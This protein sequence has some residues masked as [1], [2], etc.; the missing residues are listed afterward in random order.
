M[1]PKVSYK[2]HIAKTVT[3]RILASG[4]TYLL[5]ILFFK[6]DPDASEKAA[7]VA[8]IESALKMTFYYFHERI[9]YKIN[10]TVSTISNMRHITKTVTWRIIASVTTFLITLLIFQ[11]DPNATEKASFLMGVEALIKMAIYY[12]H[13]RVWYKINFGVERNDEKDDK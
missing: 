1:K 13:E 3:W 6:D 5:A 12:G 8:V 2:R 10:A 7:G 11:D 9:W 4:T